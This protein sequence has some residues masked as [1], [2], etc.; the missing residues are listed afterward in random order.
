[1][2]AEIN[3]IITSLMEL[4]S[5]GCHSIN[6]EYGN[7]LFRV[8]ILRLASE[9]IVYER[10]VNPVQEQT[11]LDELFGFIKNL[12]LRTRTTLHQCYK[13]EFIK[14]EKAGEWEKTKPAF[15]FGENATQAMLIDGSGYYIDDPDNGLQYF[16]DMKS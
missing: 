7:G 4:E 1:M 2:E 16:V 14:G 3:Q 9:D 10:T 12:K 13:R 15:E 6:F 11:Q 5:K 8:K